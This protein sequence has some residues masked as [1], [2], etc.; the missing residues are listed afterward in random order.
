MTACEEIHAAA[1][2]AGWEPV[3]ARPDV[4]QDYVRPA[5]VN[6]GKL[7]K[8]AEFMGWEL[9]EGI[10]VRYG[11][12]NESAVIDAVRRSPRDQAAIDGHWLGFSEEAKGRNKKGQVLAWLTAEQRQY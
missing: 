11:G 5:K 10:T 3:P 1:L 8:L 12:K 9:R 7:A 6:S 4:W 2:A